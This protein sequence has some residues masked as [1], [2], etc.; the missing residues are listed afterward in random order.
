M[1]KVDLYTQSGE[2]KGTKTLSDALFAVKINTNL[3]HQALVRQMANARYNL[4]S[5]KTR[6]EVAGGGRKPFRQKGTGRARQGTIRAPHMKGGGVAFGPTG[7]ENYSLNMPKKQR[8]L[9]LF[10]ALSQKALE[11]NVFA[12]EGY[13]GEIK[14]KVFSGL[15]SKLPVTRNAL[16]ILPEKNAVLEKSA[17]NLPHVKTLLASNINMVDLMKYQSIFLVASAPEKL[18]EV[19]L[20]HQ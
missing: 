9:A 15:L 19:F 12:L 14:T 11:K 16:F 2:K 3:M 5:T 13:E 7:K 18:E 20:S 10:S 4:A 8:R 6:A 17:R 1:V